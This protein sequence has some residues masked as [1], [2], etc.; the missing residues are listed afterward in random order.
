MAEPQA[1]VAPHTSGTSST[2]GSNA[3]QYHPSFSSPDAEI[4]FLSDDGVLFRVHRVVLQLGSGFFNGMLEMPRDADEALNNPPILI[5]DNSNVFAALLDII[6]PHRQPPELDSLDFALQ[7]LQTAENYEMHK[8]TEIVK[9]IIKSR[10]DFFLQQPIELYNIATRYGWE[11]VAKV[12]STETL[13]IN[14]HDPTMSE[15]VKRLE[16]VPLWQLVDLHWRRR[17]TFIGALNIQPTTG[18]TCN[19]VWKNIINW[20]TSCPQNIGYNSH[21]WKGNVDIAPVLILKRL[22][23]EAVDLEPWGGAIRQR[24]FL[25]KED[26]ADMWTHKCADATCRQV[27]FS[28]DRLHTELLRVL[29]LLPSTI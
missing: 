6:Y 17:R 25:D 29:D 26:L 28:K 10:L 23:A 20:A 1:D 4:V 18:P 13:T 27:V 8:V 22:L 7:I 21:F 9:C 19:I 24:S 12:A 3:P 16:S 5:R 2:S 15:S 11:D 14:L